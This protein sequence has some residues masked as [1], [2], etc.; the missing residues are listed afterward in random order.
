MSDVS[1]SA[2]VLPGQWLGMLGGGQLARMFCQAAQRMGYRVAVLDPARESPA[3]AISDLHIQCDYDDAQGLMQLARQCLAITTEF[4]NVPAQS[5]ALLA[6]YVTVRPGAKAVSVAQD[7]IREKAFFVQSGVPVAPYAAIDSEDA[8]MAAPDTLFPGILKAARFGYDGKGQARI[9]NRADAITA[10]REFGE[11][12]CVL[13]AMVPLVS[14]ISVV[15]ARDHNAT[16]QCYPPV[17]NEH[18]DG[19]LAISTS[20]ALSSQHETRRQ[21]LSVAQTVATALDYVGVL[22]VEFFVL[23]DGNLLVNEIAPRPHNSG[24]YTIDAST[25]SQFEQQVRVTAGMPVGST[26]GSQSAVMLNI[27]GDIWFRSGH[28]N[29]QEPAWEEVLAIPDAHLHLYG[30]TEVRK[31]RKMGHVNVTGAT[32][33][34]AQTTAA[35]VAN[36]LGIPFL[37]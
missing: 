18:R 33:E 25:C 2:T 20:D 11:V 37:T 34:Q 36:V 7:R 28:R 13:E 27:L 16:V 19:I 30:K 6:K 17:C 1:V 29:S 4:E 24:H 9:S 5:L 15:L 23:A 8:L 31:G 10:W 32:P 22:C 21:A 3:G 12:D 14:E 26:H 35:R